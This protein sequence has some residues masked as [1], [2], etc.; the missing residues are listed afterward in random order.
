MTVS[1][2]LKSQILMSARNLRVV[3]A[4]NARRELGDILLHSGR[5]W[6]R[7]QRDS[8]KALIRRTLTNLAS[9]PEIGQLRDDLSHGLRSHPLGSHVMYYWIADDTLIVA[10][11]LHCRQDPE[12]DDWTFVDER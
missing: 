1:P 4:R 5:T 12:L 6:G 3:L 7:T 11:I 10:H 2:D 8:Y 9:F